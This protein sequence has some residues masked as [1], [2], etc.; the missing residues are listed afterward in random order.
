MTE[1]LGVRSWLNKGQPKST[2]PGWLLAHTV[3]RPD[4]NGS[5]LL[6]TM[7]D[8]RQMQARVLKGYIVVERK[9]V[10]YTRHP[11]EMRAFLAELDEKESGAY[12]L[13]PKGTAADGRAV[14]DV[15]DLTDDTDDI[16][17]RMRGVEPPVQ[18]SESFRASTTQK[19]QKSA[20][21]PCESLAMVTTPN[22]RKFAPPKGMPPSIEMRH[23]GELKIDDSY[24][25]SI[26]TG[27]SR[28]LISKIANE[29]DWRMCLPLVVSKRADGFYVID[30]QHRLAA[31]KLRGDIPYLP[32]CVF[33]FDSVAEEAAMF[34]AM[35]RSRRAINRLDDFHAAQAGGDADVLAIT[36]MIEGVGFTVS[37]KT[38]SGA[39]A[40]GEVAFTSAIAKARR[41]Y[42]DDVARGALEIMSEAFAGQR[43]VVGSPVFTAVASVLA[44]KS[45]GADKSRLLAA[46]RTFDMAG[47]ASLIGE[48]KGGTDRN[49]HLR[50]FLVTAYSEAGA[51]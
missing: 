20:A 27:P 24:Q 4:P 50:D 8:D 44:D 47:W 9:G 37:R 3:G 51:A 5:F 17:L 18:M 48:C 10:A 30:G 34:V 45:F 49:R 33:V 42:G 46:V 36:A 38:G 13:L 25:R 6:K 40:P 28:A 21:K 43:L 23:P 29:W 12:G 41:R 31:T 1:P 35:N 11:E 16:S 19:P 7:I 15:A 2:W 26:D 22:R 14:A 39:W 32:C